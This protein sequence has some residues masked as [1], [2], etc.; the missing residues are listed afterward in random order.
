M[1]AQQQVRRTH[2]SRTDVTA[3]A[4]LPKGE[5]QTRQAAAVSQG[6]ESFVV[7]DVA[8]AFEIEDAAMHGVA[9]VTWCDV[10]NDMHRG[11]EDHALVGGDRLQAQGEFPVHLGTLAAQAAFEAA[12]SQKA[13]LEQAV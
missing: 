12:A 4:E 8:R 13:A 5:C 9:V 11:I 10:V 1:G 6:H 3:D 2:E 7:G